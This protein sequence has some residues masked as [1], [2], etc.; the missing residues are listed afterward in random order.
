VTHTE[1]NEHAEAMEKKNARPFSS[2]LAIWLG[3]LILTGLTV[4]VAVLNL[5][6][7]SVLGAIVIA[8]VKSSL[9]VLFFMNIK[10]EDRVF[11]M[12]L[13]LAIFILMV[14]LL[15]TFADVSYR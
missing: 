14:I 10:Y 8:A 5:G 4:T 13:A 12:M 2:Y 1:H 7:F 11:K 15:L 6:G 9:V 3:L